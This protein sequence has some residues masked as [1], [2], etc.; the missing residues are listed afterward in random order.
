MLV[1]LLVAAALA[2]APVAPSPARTLLILDGERALPHPGQEVVL[3]RSLTPDEGR[4]DE[5]AAAAAFLRAELDASAPLLEVLDGELEILRR[6]DAAIVGHRR[7]DAA[8]AD[9]AW[10][11]RLMHGFAAFRAFQG[12]LATAPEAARYRTLVNGQVAVASWVD[13]I[14][15]EPERLPD[16]SVLVDA[17]ARLAYQELRA[18]VLL[19]PAMTL[20]A[21]HLAPGDVLVVDG[22]ARP[23]T[24]VQVGPGEHEMVV[25]GASGVR[26]Y[27][28]VRG[29][30]GEIVTVTVSPSEADLRTVAY[31]LAAGAFEV[32]VPPSL[33]VALDSL[34]GPLDVV[35]QDAPG[36]VAYRW[37]G[38]VLRGDPAALSRTLSAN[39]A[40]AGLSLQIGA[41]AAWLYDGDYLTLHAAD[42]APQTRATVN[43]AAPGARVGLAYQRGLLRAELDADAYLPLGAWQSLPSGEGEVRLRAHPV[44]ALGAP[45][46]MATVGFLAPWHVTVGARARLPLGDR[47]A[48]D[49]AWD[50]G[51]GLPRSRDDG[52]TFSPGDAHALTLGVAWS[53]WR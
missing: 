31:A 24:T 35:L 10:R 53:A 50:Q 51:L 14:V 20:R 43:A 38:R 12:D 27:R 33:R 36:A 44:L 3:A 37:N 18:R 52:S 45:W 26:G 6:L 21:E 39:R 42:G 40:R 2:A 9:L 32:E 11:A 23:V 15:A 34:A 48:I 46:A 5:D 22:R 13:A 29:A 8:D 49:A 1:N 28:K 47:L 17:P 41:R 19:L 4:R 7:F 25:A 16:A 30:S